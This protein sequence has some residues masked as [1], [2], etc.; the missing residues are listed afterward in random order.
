MKSLIKTI[1]MLV[2]VMTGS[3]P[4]FAQSTEQDSARLE[5]A[6]IEPFRLFVTYDKTTHLIFPPRS[7]M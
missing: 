1:M 7:D 4:L 3:I 5:L 2:S 6:R